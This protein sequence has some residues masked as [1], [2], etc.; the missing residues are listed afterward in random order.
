MV[1]VAHIKL[2]IIV[3]MSTDVI[4]KDILVTPKTVET[5]NLIFIIKKFENLMQVFLKQSWVLLLMLS[6]K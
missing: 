2:F 4:A 5:T 6:T 1:L 3:L